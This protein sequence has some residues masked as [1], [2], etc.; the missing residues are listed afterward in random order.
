MKRPGE[1]YCSDCKR[2]LPCEPKTSCTTGYGVKPSGR[3][4]CFACCAIADAKAMRE[5][6]R[7]CLY[8]H[9]VTNRVTNWP[10]TLDLPVTRT[11]RG[12]HN[13]AGERLDV[14]FAFEGQSWHGVNI[15]DN[16]IV[17]CKKVAS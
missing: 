14:W 12:R 7:A 9:R 11:R 10:G 3:K 13:I 4:S 2:W 16:D 15:G 8:L 6:G 1:F 17:R 5:T